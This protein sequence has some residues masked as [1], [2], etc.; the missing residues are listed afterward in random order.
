MNMPQNLG[1]TTIQHPQFHTVTA[2]PDGITE[3]VTTFTYVKFKIKMYQIASPIVTDVYFHKNTDLNSLATK[4]IRIDKQLRKWF[5]SLPP[6]LK[7][8]QVS[9]QG[10]KEPPQDSRLFMLQALALQLAY[11]NVQILLHR[12]FLSQNMQN[13]APGPSGERNTCEDIASTSPLSSCRSPSVHCRGTQS[14]LLTSKDHCWESAIQ[15]SNLGLYGQCLEYARETHAAAFLGINLF[16]ASMVLCVFALS[17]PIST[18]AQLAKQAVTRIM[19]LS[20]FLANR[21]IL[22]GQTNQVLRDLVN[23]ILEKERR[24]ILSE[25]RDPAPA[26]FSYNQVVST[27]RDILPMNTGLPLQPESF[28]RVRDNDMIVQSPYNEQNSV[29]HTP[30]VEE[31]ANEAHSIPDFGNLNFDDGI[32]TLQE[33][34]QS[35]TYKMPIRKYQKADDKSYLAMFPGAQTQETWNIQSDVGVTS[36]QLHSG[37]R[38]MNSDI[39]VTNSIWQTW[40]WNPFPESYRG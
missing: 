5:S 36:G 30:I 38:I 23:L 18:Q 20:R 24:V 27:S 31:L 12:P 3:P 37:D 40:L 19:S 39:D 33:G 34:M 32:S 4:V 7:L 10:I 1:D 8:E 22:S 11:D 15:S 14:A 6:E 35:S 26:R 17:N 16:T 13:L 29:P 9:R 21:S 2:M 25:D 28:E